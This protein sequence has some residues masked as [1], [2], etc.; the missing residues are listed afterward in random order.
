ALAL[1]LVGGLILNLMPCVFP[2]ISLKVLGFAEQA[3]GEARKIRALGLV[4]AAGVVASFALLAAIVIGLRGSGQQLGWGFQLQ[5]PVIVTVLAIL[6]F[7]LALNI[8]GFFE[9]G[10]LVPGRVATME[11]RSPYANSFL[12]GVLAV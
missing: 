4:F 3:H 5:S 10:M 2:V 11:A 6:F 1:A 8:A 12:S 7:L 9:V